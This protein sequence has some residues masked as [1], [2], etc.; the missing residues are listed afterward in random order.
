MNKDI[1]FSYPGLGTFLTLT[2]IAITA[3]TLITILNS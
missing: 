3:A 1:F 2:L